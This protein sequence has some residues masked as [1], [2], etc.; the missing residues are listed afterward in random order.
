MTPGWPR[1][2]TS[3]CKR[4]TETVQGQRGQ[5]RRW[6]RAQGWSVEAAAAPGKVSGVTPSSA[7]PDPP[8][9][10]GH[11]YFPA[12]RANPVETKPGSNLVH[13]AGGSILARGWGCHP[14]GNRVPARVWDSHGLILTAC[15]RCPG[16]PGRPAC[17]TLPCEGQ[18][19]RYA[20]QRKVQ[21]GGVHGWDEGLLAKGGRCP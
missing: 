6:L 4:E 19:G 3:P 21:K 12:G 17:P 10:L 11:L 13:R 20:W 18:R 7:V 15:P 2:P 8:Y 1:A 16:V 9:L 5:G 14:T